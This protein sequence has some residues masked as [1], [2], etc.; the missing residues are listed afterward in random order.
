MLSVFLV[1]PAAAVPCCDDNFVDDR[2]SLTRLI[3]SSAVIF[4]NVVADHRLPLIQLLS[5][6]ILKPV[7]CQTKRR[8][9][10]QLRAVLLL[11]LSLFFGTTT[12]ADG[13][14]HWWRR[15][16]NPSFL[17]SQV[18]N[19]QALQLDIHAVIMVNVGLTGVWSG[20]VCIIHYVSHSVVGHSQTRDNFKIIYMR[21]RSKH[22]VASVYH[23]TELVDNVLC[24]LITSVVI[25][26]SNALF[27]RHPNS[28]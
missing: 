8:L 6:Q 28:S 22:V 27:S 24:E 19:F 3:D 26:W 17:G 15:F 18:A 1:W 20:F 21:P 12:I 14:E 13:G 25:S 7:D 16:T 5:L 4:W 9:G 10:I 11:S 23:S 2:R